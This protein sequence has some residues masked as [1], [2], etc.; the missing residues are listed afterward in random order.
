MIVVNTAAPVMF[1]LNRLDLWDSAPQAMKTMSYCTIYFDTWLYSYAYVLLNL[2]HRNYQM[3]VL[4][5]FKSCRTWVSNLFIARGH[6][7]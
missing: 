7:R 5:V 1:L 3:M 2:L 4:R 6:T